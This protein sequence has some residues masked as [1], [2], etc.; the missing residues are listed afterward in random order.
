[1]LRRRG[2]SSGPSGCRN[3]SGARDGTE[4][5]AGSRAAQSSGVAICGST[6]G[7]RACAPRAGASAHGLLVGHRR[8]AGRRAPRKPC[9]WSALRRHGNDLCLARQTS[10]MPSGD[11]LAQDCLCHRQRVEWPAAGHGAGHGLCP[12]IVEEAPGS[13]DSAKDAFSGDGTSG[14]GNR[15]R[16]FPLPCSRGLLVRVLPVL[17]T[18]CPASVPR[19]P[20][21]TPAQGP[22][23]SPGLGCEPAGPPRAAPRARRDARSGNRP[24]A[25]TRAIG[26][27]PRPGRS[28][29]ALA[30]SGAFCPE[31]PL[32]GA[33]AHRSG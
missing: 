32:P 18:I 22:A 12:G 4:T 30:S 15:L 20:S 8:V 5:G 7:S 9:R 1:M 28:P 21:R 33:A 6:A 13:R 19:L 24:P 16:P 26:C 14:R 3:P 17:P 25:V 23:S 27:P 2:A 10:G 31:S 29:S 11:P